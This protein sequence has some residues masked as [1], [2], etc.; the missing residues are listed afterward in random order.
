MKHGGYGGEEREVRPL[1]PR[2]VTA[3]D[4]SSLRQAVRH[5]AY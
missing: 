3:E 1:R 2:A 5:Y 4:A